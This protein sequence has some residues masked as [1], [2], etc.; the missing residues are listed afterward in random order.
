MMVC[1]EGLWV[2]LGG[3]ELCQGFLLGLMKGP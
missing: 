2:C 3:R 1:Y